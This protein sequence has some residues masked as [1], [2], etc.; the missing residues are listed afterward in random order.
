MEGNEL[1]EESNEQ[2][3]HCIS[4]VKVIKVQLR[5]ETTSLALTAK[6]STRN[7]AAIGDG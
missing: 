7:L 3:V 4:M 2:K 6:E 5:R 1:F